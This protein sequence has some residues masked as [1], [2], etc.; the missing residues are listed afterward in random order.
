MFAPTNSNSSL[1]APWQQR[2]LKIEWASLKGPIAKEIVNT[3]LVYPPQR[4][5]V[6]SAIAGKQGRPGI[7]FRRE[8]GIKSA[9]ASIRYEMLMSCASVSI[10]KHFCRFDGTSVR[11]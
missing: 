6:P 4:L 10:L 2:G 7:L 3:T 9:K 8:N 1:V 5:I 11:A